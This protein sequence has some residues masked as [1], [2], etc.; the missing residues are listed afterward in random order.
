[1]TKFYVRVH[2]G[3]VLWFLRSTTWTSEFN[4]RSTFDTTEQARAA[5]DH[6]RKFMKAAVY[7]AAV[8][9]SSEVAR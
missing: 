8:I 2:N 1:M 4:R 3:G 5:L 9:D 7:K 6:A